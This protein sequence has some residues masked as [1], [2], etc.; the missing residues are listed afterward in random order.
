MPGGVTPI[1]LFCSL[2]FRFIGRWMWWQRPL[3]IPTL[4]TVHELFTHSYIR[5]T[6]YSYVYVYIHIGDYFPLSH[7]VTL[8]HMGVRYWL[9]S[10]GESG[11]YSRDA[12]WGWLW[13]PLGT[14]FSHFLVTYCVCVRASDADGNSEICSVSQ[15]DISFDVRAP[16]Y[17]VLAM[18]DRQYSHFNCGIFLEYDEIIIL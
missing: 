3:V 14:S 10:E 8:V 17:N 7:P 1:Y 13:E 12:R 4:H 9:L 16:L 5:H 6:V 15:R 2:T 18:V 11:N